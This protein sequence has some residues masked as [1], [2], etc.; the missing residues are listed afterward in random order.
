MRLPTLSRVWTVAMILATAAALC[1]TGRRGLLSPESAQAGSA[2]PARMV[3]VEEDMHEFME[4]F[5][6]PTYR[7]LRAT[8]QS[9]ELN[10]AAWKGVK[11]DGL[12]LAEGANLL[13]IRGPEEKREQWEKLATDVREHASELYQAGKKKSGDMAGKSYRAMIESCNACHNAFADGEHQ[14][15]P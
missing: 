13:F 6:Q 9:S 3:P 8:M 4:Y 2:E 10:S 12:I 11:S 1:G 15:K 5:F 14:L 7:R